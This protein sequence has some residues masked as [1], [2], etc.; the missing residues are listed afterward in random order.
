VYIWTTITVFIYNTSD[1]VSVLKK[2]V[3]DR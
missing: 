3:E 2:Q 1:L